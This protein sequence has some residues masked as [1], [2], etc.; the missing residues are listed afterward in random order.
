MPEKIKAGVNTDRSQ[1]D[2]VYSEETKAELHKY[3]DFDE[4]LIP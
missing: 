1:W 4:S 3:L 2:Y